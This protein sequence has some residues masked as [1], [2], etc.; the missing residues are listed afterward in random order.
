MNPRPFKIIRIIFQLLLLAF[1]ILTFVNPKI[2]KNTFTFCIYQQN[3]KNNLLDNISSLS[4][5]S[6]LSVIYFSVIYFISLF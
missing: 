3:P 1:A 4:S 6:L 5:F 2:T